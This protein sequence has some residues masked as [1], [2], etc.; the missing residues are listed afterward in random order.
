M[1]FRSLDELDPADAPKVGGKA[2]NCARL[3]QHGFPVPDGLVIPAGATDLELATLGG[4][5]WFDSWAPDQ[6]FA[7]R[8]SGLAEDA[9]E[10]SFAGIHE[11]RLN[12][13]RAD[14]LD[15]VMAC[16]ASTDSDRA[17][18][19]R[20]A[21]ALPS[22]ATA[23][24]VLVQRMIQPSAA[25]VAFTIDPLSGD[26][27]EIVINSASGLGTAVVDGQIDP[28]DI[29][30][31]KQDGRVVSYRVAADASAQ[32]TARRSLTPAQV[33]AL[34]TLLVAIE[35]HYSAPQDVEWCFDGTAFWIVQSRPV[36]V[37][38]AG[39]NETEWTR[40]NLA[41]VLPEFTSPQALF[42]SEEFLKVGER[43]YFGK[44]LAP[45]EEL[46][47]IVK[48]FNG[49]LYF[50]V[51][52]L[53]RVSRLAG[54]APAAVLRSL[55]H[56]GPIDPE[57]ERIQ[58]PPLGQWIACF[59]Q[60]ARVLWRHLRAERLLRAHEA[61]VNQF[62]ARVSSVD[63]ETLTDQDTWST[64]DE[65]RQQAPQTLEVILVFGGVLIYE[66]PIKR[67]CEKVGFSY[68]RLLVS[69]L[70]AGERSVSAQQAFDLVAL[71]DTARQEP[72]AA[73]WLR[74]NEALSG[75]RQ[76]LQG[77]AFL[78]A[79]DAF[80]DR[81]GHRGIHE[82]DWALPRYREDPA[83]I[84]NAVRLHLGDDRRQD[85]SQVAARAA[86]EA[87]RVWAEFEQN[88][89]GFR[90]FTAL[91]RARRLL[92]TIKQYYLWREQC[93]S[94]MV[95]VFAAVRPWHLVLA[96]R[97][98]E[99][100][101]LAAPEDYFLLRLEEIARVIAGPAPASELRSIAAGRAADMERFRQ[102]RMPLLM[103]ESELLR[104]VRA[105]G[106]S[107]ASRDDGELRGMPVSRGCVEGEVVVIDHPGDFGKMKP[108]AILVTR[109]TDP[110]WTPL[111][112]LASGVIVE[113]GGMLSH[114]S[115]IA[116]EYGLP[117]LANV[118]HATKRLQSGDWITLN[119]TE[120]FAKKSTRER[121]H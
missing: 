55:G 96:R 46:G 112:T 54:S 80:L 73:E 6:R 106:V 42:A 29:R 50:N 83:P 51:S 65:W 23:A 5:P 75:V 41:E 99:R 111:F 86:E 116:R 82:S 88:V 44:L 69:H 45:D 71:A 70:A 98:V 34:W 94:D 117:A 30:V 67:I 31:R 60:F 68:E 90:R 4:H 57:D 76:A 49:R 17:R 25:G 72:R 74:R 26:V 81:Y 1:R 35:Q 38:T 104:L 36:T 84:L 61:S 53:R 97:F 11:T 27:E 19:Y 32:E 20:R 3:K 91:R 7:V 15:A 64:I 121:P 110:S 33:G 28:D 14:V 37:T 21:R 52:Q 2:W 12:V 24:G 114:A 66:L 39:A 102:V 109:A 107:M 113:V 40:A 56:S 87:E 119:A 63:P 10:Q 8:S 47:P 115:T 101:W 103:R 22:D 93:R 100:G 95:R 79:L 16:R 85:P 118:T 43:R 92:A 105:A 18:V 77:S 58:R 120:G 62:T 78:S 9:P 89:R 13:T 48:A 59:P 108:G